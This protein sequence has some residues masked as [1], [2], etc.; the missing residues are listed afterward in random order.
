MGY[1]PRRTNTRKSIGPATIRHIAKQIRR[2]DDATVY[3][4]SLSA[5]RTTRRVAS[6]VAHERAEAY[7]MVA[8]DVR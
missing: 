1:A 5:D 6:Q 4:L 7:A 2:M 3:A 8:D